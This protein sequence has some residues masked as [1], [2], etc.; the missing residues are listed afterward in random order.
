[1]LAGKQQLSIYLK[2]LLMVIVAVILLQ[3]KNFWVSECDVWQI[4][5]DRGGEYNLYVSH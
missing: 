3:N 2:A 4:E 1:M 5:S